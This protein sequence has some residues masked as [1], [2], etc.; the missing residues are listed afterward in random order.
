MLKSAQY[1][2]KGQFRGACSKGNIIRNCTWAPSGV[3][4][5]I[6]CLCM[7][8]VGISFISMNY[9]ERFTEVKGGT[10]YMRIREGVSARNF[11]YKPDNI[12]LAQRDSLTSLCNNIS[13]IYTL[14][15]LNEHEIRRNDGS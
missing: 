6:S 4:S 12:C 9:T 10:Q 7:L 5:Y 15:T 3:Q 2:Q 13:S 8:N 11:R 14:K 1:P